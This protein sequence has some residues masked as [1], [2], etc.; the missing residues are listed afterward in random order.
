MKSCAVSV[1]PAEMWDKNLTSIELVPFLV[2]IPLKKPSSKLVPPTPDITVPAGTACVIPA[3]T[4]AVA[5][6]PVL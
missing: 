1:F 2:I 5:K 6:V 4:A 3:P